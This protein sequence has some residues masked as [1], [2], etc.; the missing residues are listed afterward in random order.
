LLV[1][2]VRYIHHWLERAPCGSNNIGGG[3]WRDSFG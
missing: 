1:E 3:C 2:G